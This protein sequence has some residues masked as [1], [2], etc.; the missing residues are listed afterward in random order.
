MGFYQQIDHI[1]HITLDNR[2]ENIRVLTKD[3]NNLYR[4]GANCNNNTGY[5]NVTYMKNVKKKPFQVQLRI[6]GENKVLGRFSN[7]DDAVVFAEE[8]REKYYGEYRG[9]G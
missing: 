3:D 9:M 2:K 8:M 6:D 1:N 5:R 7:V 4:K